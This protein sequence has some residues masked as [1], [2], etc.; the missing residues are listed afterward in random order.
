MT[1][2]DI[3]YR[4]DAPSAHDAIARHGE[5]LAEALT[6]RGVATT[7]A[8]LSDWNEKAEAATTV[9]L[10]YNPYAYARRGV[11]PRTA[12]AIMRIASRPRVE[13]LALWVH[14]PWV[15]ARGVV[16]TGIS[17]AQRLQLRAI[18]LSAAVVIAPSCRYQRRVAG[19]IRRDVVHVPVGSNLPDC[20]ERR[21]TVRNALAVGP[22]QIIVAQ[23]GSRHPGWSPAHAQ[24]A[25][26]RI[27]S[28]AP[29]SVLLN[30]GATAPDVPEAPG[31]RVIRPGALSDKDLAGM[32]AA[33]DLFLAPFEDGLSTRRTSV[34][35]ALQHGLPVLATTTRSTDQT[36]LNSGAICGTE[37][38]P[39][40]DYGAAAE[41]IA[42][43]PARRATM[44][45][46]A[47]ELYDREFA[48]SAIA[49]RVAV[50]LDRDRG[51]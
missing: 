1:R 45:S 38:T 44:A 34:M 47:R 42:Q 12:L 19:L 13:R 7:T 26:K 22:D 43:D 30:L 23:L 39:V 33:S 50:L 35:A 3:L 28:A 37:L 25:A 36:F 24:A 49:E 20:R 5:L 48:W 18:S 46:A 11:S 15:P 29:G 41:A 9:L 4:W 31:I 32:L 21:S 51:K 40:E 17:A 27:G 16:A 10:Q 14:E 8:S 2:V 6:S